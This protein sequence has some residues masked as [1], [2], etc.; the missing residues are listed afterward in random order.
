MS[1]L[2]SFCGCAL[3][4]LKSFPITF[5]VSTSPNSWVVMFSLAVDVARLKLQLQLQVVLDVSRYYPLPSFFPPP[6]PLLLQEKT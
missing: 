6:L 5:Y 3:E 1:T 4:L 2:S